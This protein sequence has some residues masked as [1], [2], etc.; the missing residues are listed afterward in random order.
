VRDLAAAINNEDPVG[1]AEVLAPDEVKTL[2]GLLGD[3]ESRASKT[4]IGGDKKSLGGIDVSIEDLQLEVD[5]LSDTVAKVEIRDG[6]AAWKITPDNLGATT[7]RAVGEIE[8][9]SGNIDTEDLVVSGYDDRDGSEFEIDPF[10][11]AVKR[12]GGWYVSLTYTVAAYVTEANGYQAGDFDEEVPTNLEAAKT[13][14]EAVTGLA[15]SLDEMDPTET[16]T[17]L[18][19]Y[20]FAFLHAYR[21]AIEDA[22]DEATADGEGF[23]FEVDDSDLE[24][25]DLPGGYKKVTIKRSSGEASTTDQY[26]DRSQVTWELDDLCLSTRGD[27]DRERGCIAD[28][29]D[30]EAWSELV[31]TVG[32]KQPFIVVQEARGGW[33]VSP[34]AT[35]AQY[36]KEILPKLSD[37]WIY[38]MFDMETAAPPQGTVTVG[39][40]VRVT[41]NE[42]GY[43]TY[44]VALEKGQR[45]TGGSEAD[46]DSRDP[47]TWLCLQLDDECDSLYEVQ[48]PEQAGT[49]PLVV[50]GEAH[51]TV[52]IQILDVRVEDMPS[53]GHMV[54]DMD[55][56][57]QAI[58]Y[59]FQVSNSGYIRLSGFGSDMA[60]VV[61]DDESSWVV[62]NFFGDCQLTAGTS[63]RVRLQGEGP[64]DIE[65]IQGGPYSIDGEQS[66][67]GSLGIEDTATHWIAVEDGETATVTLESPTGADFDVTCEPDCGGNSSAYSP[68]SF[69]VYGP[70][71]GTLEVYAYSG[72]GSYTLTIED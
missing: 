41:I 7:R 54:G 31:D 34:M 67:T 21:D 2:T 11:I 53:D 57:Y 37:A 32:I 63:Y 72:S 46:G 22:I 10:V 15:N 61:G 42:A 16:L 51:S 48:V 20:E 26:G 9:T 47:D 55:D 66:V 68:E 6:R 19:E 36:G 60:T 29:D 52:Q 18:P 59:R 56:G 3:I 45:I 33:A 1:A 44:Q 62:C 30:E 28:S 17:F 49:F 65:L 24:V 13:P 35:L 64:Y 4:G 40:P 43:A 25:S 8:E 70:I 23:T 12:K 27:G 71:S 39:K 50:W 38:R 14:E 69:I 5:E 58:E